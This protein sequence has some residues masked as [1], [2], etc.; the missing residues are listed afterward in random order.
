[1]TLFT[2]L[3]IGFAAS[4]STCMAL[5]GGLVLAISA[6]YAEKHPEKSI[7][8]KFTPHLYFNAGRIIG[9]TILGGLIGELGKIAQFPTS[10][11]TILTILVGV[12]MILLGLKLINIFPVFNKISFTLPISIARL[13]GAHK[14]P[15]KY[16][17]RG[18]FLAGALTFFLPCGFTQAVQLY[19]MST[20][21]WQSGA[22]AMAVFAI[23]TAPGLLGIG[24][25]SSVL[26]GPKARVFSVV[27]GI[28]VLVFGIT[29]IVRGVKMFN[30][31]QANNQPVK[32][33]V[34][35]S[36]EVQTVYMKQGISGYSPNEFTVEKGKK[37]RWVINSTNPYTCASSIIVPAYGVERY[38][39]KGEN[40]IEFTPTKSGIVQFSCSMGMYRGQFIVK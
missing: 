13:F 11:Y 30:S 40:I 29:G 24:G 6:R 20:G 37:V 4:V 38:L 5:V 35:I 3:L 2:I 12:V 36:D 22:A 23:G 28:L 1:M 14:E 15:E 25:L 39:Q 10:V 7:K 32:E 8:Q 26:A 9:F 18:A 31:R 34:V 27:A 21:S 16:S 17:H 33:N 19:A